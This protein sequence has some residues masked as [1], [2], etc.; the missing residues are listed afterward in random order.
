MIASPVPEPSM[1]FGNTEI[2]VVFLC[3]LDKDLTHF[4]CGL[5]VFGL[6]SVYASRVYF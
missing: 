2:K 1:Y 4:G 6:F 5:L 3:F